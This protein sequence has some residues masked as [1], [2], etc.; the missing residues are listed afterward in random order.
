MCGKG[1][2]PLSKNARDRLILVPSQAPPPLFRRTSGHRPDS[3]RSP[4]GPGLSQP[5]SLRGV[6]Q[7][8]SPLIGLFVRDCSVIC[9]HNNPFWER[10]GLGRLFPRPNPTV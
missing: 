1:A 2:G 10:G 6:V 7:K 9:Y 8:T 4:P 5:L 3:V